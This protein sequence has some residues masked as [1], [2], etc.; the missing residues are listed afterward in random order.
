MSSTNKYFLSILSSESAIGILFNFFFSNI[1][2][3]IR[4]T[5]LI[6]HF[7]HSLILA[8]LNKK[9]EKFTPFLDSYLSVS[10]FP[11]NFPLEIDYLV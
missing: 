3:S 11:K 8:S 7:K 9:S 6:L 2:F 1:S 4:K 10:Y 5:S